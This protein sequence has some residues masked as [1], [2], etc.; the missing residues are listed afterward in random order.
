MSDLFNGKF[1][2][3]S[4][5]RRKYALSTNFDSWFT[6]CVLSQQN[7]VSVEVVLRTF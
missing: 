5:L 4:S 6:Y 1:Q 2:E 3:M 7:S